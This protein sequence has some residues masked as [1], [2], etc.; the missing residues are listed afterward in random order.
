MFVS[1]CISKY[2]SDPLLENILK[3]LAHRLHISLPHHR[4]MRRTQL[5]RRGILWRTSTSLRPA[6]VALS[7]ASGLRARRRRLVGTSLRRR[8]SLLRMM[9]ARR[10]AGRRWPGVSNRL[11]YVS[12]LSSI[13]LSPVNFVC[14][15]ADSPQ[16]AKAAEEG[17]VSLT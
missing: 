12:M 9:T 6:R 11:R 17:A 13:S 2:W 8:Q 16:D 3:C 10:R 4:R 1:S 14:Q 5:R 7:V 15:D